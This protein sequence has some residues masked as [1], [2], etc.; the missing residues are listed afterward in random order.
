MTD[1]ASNNREKIDQ[2]RHRLAI[3]ELSYE[4]AL[5]IAAPVIASMNERAEAIAKKHKRRPI[6]FTFISLMR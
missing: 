3:G 4:E 2:V 5:A 1:E 6:K